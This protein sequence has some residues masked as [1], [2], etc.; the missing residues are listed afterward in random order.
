MRERSHPSSWPRRRRSRTSTGRNTSPWSGLAYALSGSRWLAEELAQEAFLA[1][2]RNWARIAAYDQPGAW[3]RRVVTNLSVSAFRR[4]SS[5]RRRS[6]ASALASD[7]ANPTEPAGD[8]E[9]WEAVRSLPRRQSQV[10]TLHYLED[11]SGRR[12]RG[13]PRHGAGHRE[14]APARRAPDTRP[15]AADRGGRAMNLDERGRRAA[16]DSRPR[17]RRIAGRSAGRIPFERFER[18]VARRTPHQRVA[19]ASWP[20]CRRP[21]R[22]LPRADVRTG[23]AR[24]PRAPLPS[25]PILY[26]DWDQRT[27][28]A[29][30]TRLPTDGSSETSASTPRA[31]RGSPTGA[32]SWYRTTPASARTSP[33]R[34]AVIEPDG[35]D[36]REL[37]G[38][39]DPDLNLGAATFR[40]RHADRARGLQRPG[41]RHATA[42]TRCALPTAAT[43]PTDLRARRGS[44]LLARRG[45]GGLLPDET[46]ASIPT[47]PARCSSSAPTVGARPD[48]AV[49]FGLHR[50]GVVSR[51]VAGSRSSGRTGGSSSCTPTAAACTEVSVEL[52]AGSGA[53]EPSWS[54]DGRVDRLLIDAGRRCGPVRGPTR[55]HGTHAADRLA[56]E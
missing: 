55:R 26:G 47:G 14:E 44:D 49:G 36:L 29:T 40:G 23:P 53:R 9:F 33:L 51:T 56:A 42:S 1:A 7:L 31:P 37:D 25:G 10:V 18:A 54:P 28:L 12:G 2:H 39:H 6:S 5:R 24:L 48:H 46:R 16:G 32:G 52:P 45:A 19:A 20:W 38:S 30:G 43:S 8:A 11:L 4:R 35:S 17:G 3:V 50:S 21:G 13:G 15:P 27:P 41:H 34:P 22:D